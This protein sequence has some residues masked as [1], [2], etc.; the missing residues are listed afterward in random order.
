M[1]MEELD[2]VNISTEE[3]V[4]IY[5]LIEAFINNIDKEIKSLEVKKDEK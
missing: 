4:E 5:K 1:L 3:L 2:L